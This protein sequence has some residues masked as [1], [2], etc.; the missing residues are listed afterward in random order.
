MSTLST[1]QH[2]F[3]MLWYW[4]YVEFGKK[5]RKDLPARWYVLSGFSPSELLAYPTPE[6][7]GVLVEMHSILWPSL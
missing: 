7:S 2:T 5:Y 6:L 1:P 4:V 3:L